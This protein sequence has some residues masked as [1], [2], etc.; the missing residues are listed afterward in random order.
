MALYELKTDFV[1]YGLT[2]AR[3]VNYVA[4]GSNL[5]HVTTENVFHMRYYFITFVAILNYNKGVNARLCSYL[6]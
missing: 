4:S 3:F 1:W 2:S 6:C 5:K